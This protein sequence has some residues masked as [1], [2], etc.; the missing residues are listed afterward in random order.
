MPPLLD[1]APAG[2]V[3]W[4]QIM[5]HYVLWPAAVSSPAILAIVALRR[6]VTWPIADLAAFVILW[7][8]VLLWVGSCA[9]SVL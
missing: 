1:L 5:A 8:F 3:A 9:L 6:W 2:G 7:Y 4:L